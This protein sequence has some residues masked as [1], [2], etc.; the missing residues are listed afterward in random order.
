M[1]A[2]P[3]V[4]MVDIRKHFGAV[5]VLRGV[6]LAVAKGEVIGLVIETHC[7]YFSPLAFPR[8]VEAG[9]RV[10]HIGKSSVRYEIGLFEQG[11]AQSAASGHF[12]HVYVDRVTRRPTE[13]PEAFVQ[14]LKALQVPA[15]A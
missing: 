10:A 6:N 5:K 14:A 4:E 3:R 1:N 7:N 15:A 9:I 12:V 11:E 8:N 13:L 2:A